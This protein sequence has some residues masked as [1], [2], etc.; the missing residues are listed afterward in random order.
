[1]SILLPQLSKSYSHSIILPA[2]VTLSLG[3]YDCLCI[4]LLCSSVLSL[5]RLLKVG[6]PS[7]MR[8]VHWAHTEMQPGQSVRGSELLF[9]LTCKFFHRWLTL[10][11]QRGVLWTITYSNP[12]PSSQPLFVLWYAVFLAWVSVECHICFCL[13]LL[14]TISA[15]RWPLLSCLSSE[16]RSLL[17]HGMPW[18]VF[19]E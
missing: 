18:V 11:S 16:A 12:F 8:G 17:T 14:N 15:W 5:T 2:W 4:H 13:L 1:M 7:S 3:V 10:C 19:V 9:L 6:H